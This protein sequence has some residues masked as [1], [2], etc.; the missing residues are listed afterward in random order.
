[1]FIYSISKVQTSDYVHTANDNPSCRYFHTDLTY[2]NFI[3]P[4]KLG[5]GQRF[6]GLEPSKV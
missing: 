1:M 5:L 6:E 2:C 3:L 4:L